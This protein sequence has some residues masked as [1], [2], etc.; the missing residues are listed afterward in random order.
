MTMTMTFYALSSSSFSRNPPIPA[1]SFPSLSRVS[2]LNGA[3]KL[4]FAPPQFLNAGASLRGEF[5]TV[6]LRV[7][8]RCER[9]NAHN[10]EVVDDAE[11]FPRRES[12]MPDRFRYLTREAQDSPIRWPWFLGTTP[13]SLPV[14]Y[15]F[16]I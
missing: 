9:E 13:F 8:T 15:F 1:I 14:H 11:R 6:R 10:G 3:N 4:T 7:S 16:C 12:T 2:Q 5:P